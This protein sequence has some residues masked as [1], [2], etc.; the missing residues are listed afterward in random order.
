MYGLFVQQALGQFV[1]HPRG[2]A[3]FGLG[4]GEDF[5]EA[6]TDVGQVRG[7]AGQFRA[8][9]LEGDVDQPAGVDHVVGGVEDPAPFQLIG[10]LQVGQL[11][12]GRTGHGRAPQLAD[13]LAIEHGAQAARGEDIAGS[14]EQ[15]VI[16]NRVRAQ[17]LHGQLHLAVIDIAH[18]QFGAGGMQLFGQGK[19]DVAQALH[20]HAQAF[21]VIAAQAGHSGG[22]NAREHAHGCVGRWVAGRRGAGDE[23]GLLGDAVHVSHRGAAVDG[24]D[25]AAVEFFDTT[26][27]G[28]KQCG[29]AFHVHWA[30]DHC[31]AAAHWQS[32][33]SGLVAHALG[34]ARGIGHGTF[35]VGV[36]EITTAAKGRAEA[37]VMNGDDR[38]QP[39]DRVDAQVQ[40]FK[41]GAVHESKHRQA[42]ES[43]LVVGQV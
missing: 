42:P 33:E 7:D 29:A 11:R 27:K 21:E 39:G 9:V 8:A 17:L 15:G 1:R 31:R 16:G 12:T 19:T 36:G 32:G 18:Q 4:M 28:F 5:S 10:D 38:L 3:F 13:T 40:R 20:R 24:N 41:A 43:L 14:A 30:Q 22:A 34:Q 2:A 6:C 23:A 37:A 25:E 26:A 35:V